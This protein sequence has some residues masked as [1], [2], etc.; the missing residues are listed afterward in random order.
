LLDVIAQYTAYCNCC[1]EDR[2]I[3]ERYF[4]AGFKYKSII[5]FLSDY[6]G[7]HISTR[8]LRRRLADYGL[9]RRQ[10]GTS[11]V[12]IW[13]AI[14]V[15]LQGPGLYIVPYLKMYCF[16]AVHTKKLEIISPVT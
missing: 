16:H 2:E 9:S 10:H 7:L 4:W 6:H 8:T 15:E 11:L 3:I 1:R 12:D 13:D 5:R 14:H